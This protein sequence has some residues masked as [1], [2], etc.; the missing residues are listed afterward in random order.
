MCSPNSRAAN[1]RWHIWRCSG[2][3]LCVRHC[4]AI[5]RACPSAR[6]PG[7]QGHL[8]PGR[9]RACRRPAVS[10]NRSK[11]ARRFGKPKRRACSCREN[12]RLCRWRPRLKSFCF[13]HRA[14]R[15]PAARL[16]KR[17]SL[18]QTGAARLWAAGQMISVRLVMPAGKSSYCALTRRVSGS[19]VGY[20]PGTSGASKLRVQNRCSPAPLRQTAS[21][22]GT[23][24]LYTSFYSAASSAVR[25][26][27]SS[28]VSRP[29]MPCANF[30][31]FSRPMR[32]AVRSMKN[33]LLL[34]QGEIIAGVPLRAAQ[35]LAEHAPILAQPPP[36]SSQGRF[37]ARTPRT[38]AGGSPAGRSIPQF[39]SARTALRWNGFGRLYQSSEGFLP[40]R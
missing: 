21:P 15:L 32:L 3:Q 4:K 22:A 37:P 8:P 33:W 11:Q 9:C 12:H 29:A 1:G 7:R 31:A 18:F 27:R 28:H 30:S 10:M 26:F 34:L 5:R 23:G 2:T 36:Q 20:G 35:R 13:R 40:L 38:Y 16:T 39:W 19:A 25:A 24:A 14:K 6:L 17:E